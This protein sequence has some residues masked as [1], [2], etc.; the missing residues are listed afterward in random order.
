MS[1]FANLGQYDTLLSF[2]TAINSCQI[3][4][5]VLLCRPLEYKVI[6]VLDG[7]DEYTR[8]VN[9]AIDRA[10]EKQSLWKWWLLLTSRPSDKVQIIR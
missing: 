7:Y 3:Y 5:K 6:L 8:G 1:H 10:I 9:K 2:Q 4:T